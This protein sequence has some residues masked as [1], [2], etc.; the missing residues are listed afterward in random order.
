MPFQ[1]SQY[2]DPGY[3]ARPITPLQITISEGSSSPTVPVSCGTAN[4]K[5]HLN[6]FVCPGNPPA[7]HRDG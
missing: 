2:A 4:G 5:M 1:Q 6:M 3:A 7:V